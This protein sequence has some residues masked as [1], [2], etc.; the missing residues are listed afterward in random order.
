VV[1]PRTIRIELDD[2]GA[3]ALHAALIAA[4][5]SDTARDVLEQLERQMPELAEAATLN[6]GEALVDL[7]YAE[8]RPGRWAYRPAVQAIA[9]LQDAGFDV[10]A[11]ELRKRGLLE[12]TEG[13]DLELTDAGAEL[14]RERWAASSS[15]PHWRI[16]APPLPYRRLPVRVEPEDRRCRARGCDG[17]ATWLKPKGRSAAFKALLQDGAVEW[18]CPQC[19]R[20][21]T[22]YLQAYDDDGAPAYRDPVDGTYNRPLWRRSR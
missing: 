20:R 22:I 13:D 15:L 3:R 2:D 16:P 1:A 21:W 9:R 11:G 17:E 19:S 12:A 4:A 7:V 6:D 14:A 18:A 5:A 10:L 8:H